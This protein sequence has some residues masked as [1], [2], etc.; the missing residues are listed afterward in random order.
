VIAVDKDYGSN[1]SI[2]YSL[3]SIRPRAD[4]P[5]LTI[6]AKT[7]QLTLLRLIPPDW[8]GRQM[9]AVVLAMDGGGLS[10][11]ATITVHLVSHDGPRFSASHYTASVSESAPIGEAVT[12]VEASSPNPAISLIYR[13]VSVR[14][15]NS[16]AGAD[17]PN[18]MS[19]EVTDSP[20]MLEFNT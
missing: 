2:A 14:T 1:G 19:V 15:L 6:D 9:D 10:A 11:S 4:P 18:W 5:L 17:V 20:F 8:T 12:T 7:G 13:V 3:T 16:S